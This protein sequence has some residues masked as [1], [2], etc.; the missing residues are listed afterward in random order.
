MKRPCDVEDAGDPA[1]KSR[2]QGLVRIPLEK[3]GFWPGN[4][5]GL[6]VSPH[7]AHEVA[8]DCVANKTK[9]QRYGHVD[10]MEIPPHLLDEIRKANRSLCE[11]DAL[12]PRYS[13][14]FEY[15]CASKTQFLHAQKLGKEGNRTSFNNGDVPIRWQEGDIKDVHGATHFFI[16]PKSFDL[17]L[18]YKSDYM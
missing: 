2:K 16:S 3:I 17:Y 13:D 14:S 18:N 15:V 9:L 4:R 7:H 11:A 12:M 8:C 1:Q 5:G 10:L 6:G